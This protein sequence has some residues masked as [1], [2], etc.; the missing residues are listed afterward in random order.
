MAQSLNDALFDAFMSNFNTLT[1]QQM[2]Y[3]LRGVIYQYCVDHGLSVFD[4]EPDGIAYIR[5]LVGKV[6]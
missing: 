6:A 2:F 5:Q 3:F 4:T 1:P